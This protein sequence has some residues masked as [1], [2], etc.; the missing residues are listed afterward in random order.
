MARNQ[1][2]KLYKQLLEESA[3]FSDYNFRCHS[4]RR[5]KYCYEK[6]LNETSDEKLEAIVTKAAKDLQVI[7]RQVVVGRLYAV[8]HHILDREPTT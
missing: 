2:A 6:H 4:V 8:E 3:K 1:L 7:Q 5:M